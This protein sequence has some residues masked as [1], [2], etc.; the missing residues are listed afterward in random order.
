VGLVAACD[1]HGPRRGHFRGALQGAR[2]GWIVPS[3]QHPAPAEVW[4]DLKA[5]LGPAAQ[6]GGRVSEEQRLIVVPGGGSVQVWSGHDPD[7][8]RGPYFDGEVV[9]ECSIQDARV[10]AALRPTLSDYGGWGMLCGTVPEDVS[11][12]WFV[13]MQPH[14]DFCH[15]LGIVDHGH[16]ATDGLSITNSPPVSLPQDAATRSW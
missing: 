10:W 9:D 6:V 16:Y 5:A 14:L 4:A 3:E 8:L 13:L 12:H 2:I 7:R 1:G 11:G 15:W